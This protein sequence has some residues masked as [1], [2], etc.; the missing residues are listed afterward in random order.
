MSQKQQNK[1]MKQVLFLSVSS[2]HTCKFPVTNKED[3]L[4]NFLAMFNCMIVFNILIRIM[5]GVRID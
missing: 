1:L 4:G 2:L 3:T 5:K